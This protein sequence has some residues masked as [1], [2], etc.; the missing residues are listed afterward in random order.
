MTL[1]LSYSDSLVV[2][3]QE[4]I[5]ELLVRSLPRLRLEPLVSEDSGQA[6]GLLVPPLV[7]ERVVSDFKFS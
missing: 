1:S 5:H 2:N 3:A 6:V 4:V 7:H